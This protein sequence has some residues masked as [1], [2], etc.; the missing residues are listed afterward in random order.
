VENGGLAASHLT[1]PIRHQRGT[2]SFLVYRRKY[3]VNRDRATEFRKECLPGDLAVFAGRALPLVVLVDH[4]HGSF[5][6]ARPGTVDADVTGQQVL[7]GVGEAVGTDPDQ[8]SGAQ[9]AHLVP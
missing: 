9:A 4:V 7:L 8:P 1:C 2:T 6:G 3:V 5:L